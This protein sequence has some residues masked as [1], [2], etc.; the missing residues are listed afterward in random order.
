MTK[1]WE[2]VHV[3]ISSTFDDMHA[4]RDYLVKQVFPELR[5]WCERRKLNLVDI[6]LR[7]G[8]REEDTQTKSV[9]EVCLNSIDKA[10]PFFLCFLGQRRGWVPQ[11][12]DISPSTL[13]QKSFPDLQNAIGNASVTEMEIIHALINPFHRSR[14]NKD[15]TT[16]Y[17][18]PVKYAF[19]YF[20]DPSYLNE[21]PAILNDVYTNSGAR[22]DDGKKNESKCQEEDRELKR[23]QTKEIPDVCKK[24]H[25]PDPHW[26]NAEWDS[27]A[28]TPE[29]NLPLEC[30]SESESSIKL[31]QRKW[32]EAGIV[33]TNTRI[34]DPD[35]IKEA[36]AYNQQRSGGRLTNFQSQGTN[37][38]Q[39]VLNDL[40]V[41]ISERYPDHFEI[42]KQTDLQQEIDQQEQFLHSSSEGF[43]F[44]GD[45]FGA[46]NN[47]VSGDDQRLFILHAP[48][49]AGKST[50]LSKWIETCRSENESQPNRSIHFR[51]IGQSD[52]STSVYSLLYFLLWEIK[53]ITGK[54]KE[55]IPINPQ[56][57]RQQ[58]PALLEA[59]GKKG[60]TIIVLDG[61]N[62]LESGLADLSWLPYQLPQNIKL[63]VS[64]KSE[65]PAA[66][67]LLMQIKERAVLAEVNPFS[68]LEDRKKLVKEYL[69]QYLKDL[70]DRYRDILIQSAGA[71]NPLFLKVVLSELRV[72][73]A[74]SNL[75]E[76]IRMDFGE[77]PISAF[78]G[79]LN[80]LENDPAYSPI[81]PKRVVPFLFGLLSHSQW[82]LTL[83]EL[84][85]L[86][87]EEFKVTTQEAQDSINHYLRQVRSF[88]AHRDGYYDFFFESFKIAARNRY[89][90]KTQNSRTNQEWHSLLA[91]YF[92]D[93]PLT[94]EK[95]GDNVPN[96]H[97]LEELPYQL[98]NS[99]MADEL[100]KTLTNYWFLESKI[101]TLGVPALLSDFDRALATEKFLA[102]DV[103]NSLVLIRDSVK[104]SEY[105]LTKNKHLLAG[106]LHARMVEI[107]DERVFNLLKE[108]KTKKDLPWLCPIEK[109]LQSPLESEERS[110]NLER[111][112]FLDFSP[113]GE[114]FITQSFQVWNITTGL[115]ENTLTNPYSLYQNWSSYPHAF[116]S[117]GT[118]FA[119]A[120]EEG[121]I[122]VWNI[123]TSQLI[124][125]LVDPSIKFVE[126][127]ENQRT[128]PTKVYSGEI[129]HIS[130][131]K[132]GG[133]LF[134]VVGDQVNVWDLIKGELIRTM[135]KEYDWT[136]QNPYNGSRQK[137]LTKNEGK[138]AIQFAKDRTIRVWDLETGVCKHLFK[139]EYTSDSFSDDV[140]KI[141]FSERITSN[142]SFNI[143]NIDSGVIEK[144]YQ[145]SDS[146][147]AFVVL[148][149]QH[150]IA[151]TGNKGW[152]IWDMDNDVA[153]KPIPGL[154]TGGS[155]SQWLITNN[156]RYAIANSGNL[157]I[158]DL[159]SGKLNQN[160]K[161]LE[162]KIILRPDGLHVA[163][164]N[165]HRI[166]LI[167]PSR[168]QASEVQV[169]SSSYY[170]PT[171][172]DDGKLVVA[173][174]SNI[175]FFNVENGNQIG[176]LERGYLQPHQDLLLLP[177]NQTLITF[178]EGSIK[179][180]DLHH[181]NKPETIREES[182]RNIW[183]K[184]PILVSP[185]GQQII[186]RSDQDEIK[187]WNINAPHNEKFVGR[188]TFT[189]H[190]KQM[191]ISPDG[192]KV[193][194]ATNPMR[195][196]TSPYAQEKTHDTKIEH[197]QDEE[198]PSIKVWDLS[199]P[200]KVIN[201]YEEKYHT[202]EFCISPDGKWC[203][204]ESTTLNPN[205]LVDDQHIA[206][207]N[208]D[209]GLETKPIRGYKN[210]PN[211]HSSI[212][213]IML[214]PDGEKLVAFWEEI[215]RTWSLPDQQEKSVELPEISNSASPISLPRP[216]ILPDASGVVFSQDGIM[217]KYCDFKTMHLKDLYYTDLPITNIFIPP[218]SKKIVTRNSAGQI[219]YFS[220]EGIE[221]A[222]LLVTAWKSKEPKIFGTIKYAFGCPVCR[223]WT[224]I[225]QSNLDSVFSCPNCQQSLKINPFVFDGD[226]RA[227][228][229]AWKTDNKNSVFVLP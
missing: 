153:A 101:G 53:E 223:V 202:P 45:D 196:F 111:E 117:D 190:I 91:T 160:S 133:L 2:T 156:G 81:E 43:I 140:M 191:Q 112:A 225:S 175:T 9:V 103:Q 173:E 104:L 109:A 52:R 23:W 80:R 154:A 171:M 135:Q 57:L 83:E 120:F 204:F 183:G 82:G 152:V 21:L 189:N 187:I 64:F 147:A 126:M 134:S 99:G 129:D 124:H 228:A 144:K 166:I 107:K 7:W 34:T 3:F 12:S 148:Q 54:F 172:S 46:I 220:F 224:E 210:K 211:S 157:L 110:I 176:F 138:L 89:A 201:L 15:Q 215:L 38:S 63:I 169:I 19:F 163:I 97:K 26:Y 65:V 37:L 42:E 174:G 113:D 188:H 158:W 222:P 44:R 199:N 13:D 66:E 205:F 87:I 194:T 40:K 177:N 182:K 8:V 139:G 92:Y 136:G 193:V 149:D 200:E 209:T 25:Q 59:A 90:M 150:R 168:S 35:Q 167:N 67:T 32:A 164:G 16:E 161:G 48:G 141:A 36:E 39:M 47:Y 27:K 51:F 68:N 10:R 96:K 58:L 29:L 186:E 127:R 22:N 24:N 206:C 71:E 62:Q 121:S 159:L 30:P 95:N 14:I 221:L 155:G 192:N 55:E 184:N 11:E 73:G 56:K 151:I 86:F 28:T 146:A 76:K 78:E 213:K 100:E 74:F 125:K 93:Q 178:A 75:K 219:Q 203:Y 142:V 79:V 123:L 128:A 218:N 179:I 108:A 4:E 217:L 170:N 61:L 94:R 122:I 106:Q 130:F 195:N 212:N 115:K 132:N 41:A 49:G 114:R 181:P 17:Y 118:L 5:E 102:E 77:T 137:I 88:L 20:R 69:A 84:N 165:E 116:S 143:G 162:G 214:T 85:D 50:L 119:L 31:W 33:V 72:F 216:V 226:W 185:N 198:K 207:M 227:I 105:A 208:L 180:W 131:S 98:T 1:N 145:Y 60:R 229:E 70:D 6:D 197:P 18:D